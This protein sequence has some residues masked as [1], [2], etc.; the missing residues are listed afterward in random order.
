MTGSRSGNGFV[1]LLHG[2]DWFVIRLEDDIALPDS[3]FVGWTVRHHLLDDNAGLLRDIKMD[4]KLI[5][6]RNPNDPDPPACGF[7]FLRLGCLD[8]W[9][10]TL[11]KLTPALGAR[12]G[13]LDLRCRASR[14]NRPSLVRLFRTWRLILGKCR[15]R[16]GGKK[17]Q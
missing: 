17:S 8:V 15:N 12:P 9:P 10:A 13:T 5:L 14:L 11:L 3:R 6:D 16:H 4:A 1:Q 2:S 7:L